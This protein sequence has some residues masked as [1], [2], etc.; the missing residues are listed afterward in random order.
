MNTIGLIIKKT[1]LVV[2]IGA[3]CL[4]SLPLSN[5]AALSVTEPATPP[6]PF[7]NAT[8]RLEQAWAREQTIYSKLNLFFSNIDQRI[9]QGQALIDRATAKGKDT[10]SLQSALDAFSAAVK[11]AEPI[12][13]STQAD[14]A[15]HP[16]FDDNGKVTD[17]T[18]AFTTVLT[19]GEKFREIRQ[20]LME[21]G[22]ALREA[23]KTFRSQNM[24]PTPT[25]PNQSGS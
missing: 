21:P 11:Q 2:L 10:S 22:N 3:F 14:F 24:P 5:V 19:L 15:S 13:Q 6:A 1:W 4:T 20:L 12:F 7:Q 16:G 17:P 18:Q 23:I 9:A 8:Q 25:T